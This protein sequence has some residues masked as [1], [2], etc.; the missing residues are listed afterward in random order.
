[1]I[2][3]S[4]GQDYSVESKHF[5]CLVKTS[6]E[7]GVDLKK[8][9]SNFEK[10][11]IAA[12]ALA[13]NSGNSYYR[14]YEK[15]K[16]TGDVSYVFQY[17][18][19]DSI[20]SSANN[21]EF[22][23]LGG[24][25]IKLAEKTQRT[26][27]YQKS[28][29]FQL[30]LSMDSIRNSQNIYIKEVADVILRILSPED[31]D[32]DYYKMT[33]LLMLAA[34]QDVS[35]G[36]ERKLPPIAENTDGAPINKRNLLVVHVTTDNDSVILNNTKVS[37]EDLT[38]IVERY[39]ISD[40]KDT[41]MPE[42]ILVNIDLIGDCFQSNLVISLQ[43]ERETSYSTYVEVQN[44]LIKAYRRVRND[45]AMEFFNLEFDELSVDQQNSIKQLIPISI[46]E[47]EP[48]Q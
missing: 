39:L 14:L 34:T 18:L 35:T 42:M 28:K 27:R 16:E 26:R 40:S 3:Y 17:S 43:N 31:F 22:K 44:K 41:T 33:A 1:M 36:I 23:D 13:D 32:H 37:I 30:K 21:I 8:E 38:D 29:L 4:F 12:G 20:R 7:L 5:N 46:S 25:C 24:D 19:F 10:H 6:A 47:A 9:L 11:L 48:K 45:K 2:N 15:I